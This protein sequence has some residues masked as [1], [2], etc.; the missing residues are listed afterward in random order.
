MENKKSASEM[1]KSLERTYEK[2]KRKKIIKKMG[3]MIEELTE[4]KVR[5]V[6]CLVDESRLTQEGGAQLWGYELYE[7]IVIDSSAVG[8]SIFHN[9][10][11]DG[12]NRIKTA[13]DGAPDAENNCELPHSLQRINSQIHKTNWDKNYSYNELTKNWDK[14]EFF[15]NTF[16]YKRKKIGEIKNKD[17]IKLINIGIVDQKEGSGKLELELGFDEGVIEKFISSYKLKKNE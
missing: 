8:V 16:D 1:K 4:K 14:T 5:I 7:G 12:M 9:R 10:F 15:E 6:P 11:E 2:E 3:E 17:E 13:M